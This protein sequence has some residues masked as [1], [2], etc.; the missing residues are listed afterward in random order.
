[1]F[2]ALDAGG[3]S[4]RAALVDAAGRCLGY[5]RA[6]GGNP[7]SAGIENAVAAAGQA[8]EAA[9]AG[10]DGAVEGPTPAVIA[11]AGEK[12]RGL[13]GADRGAAGRAGRRTGA[14][15]T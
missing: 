10:T 15:G 11:M 6:G 3:T 13:S 1:M 4:T 2:L 5:G 12:T 14:A 8:A 9:L 7:T